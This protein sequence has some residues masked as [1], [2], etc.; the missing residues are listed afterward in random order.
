VVDLDTALSQQLLQ[1]PV[2]QAVAQVPA[3]RD[4]DHLGWE[5]EP[6]ERRPIDLGVAD[7]TTTHRH[8]LLPPTPSTGCTRSTQQSLRLLLVVLTVVM[9]LVLAVLIVIRASRG[10]DPQPPAPGANPRSSVDCL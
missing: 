2:G 6:S 3:D 7:T 10:C 1:I 9:A 8:S 5:P 4:R